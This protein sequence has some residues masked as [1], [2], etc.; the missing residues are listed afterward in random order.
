MI[1]NRIP[2]KTDSPDE[3]K[4]AHAD[5]VGDEDLNPE[6][7]KP[8]SKE[9][10]KFQ[11][12][13]QVFLVAAVSLGML[14]CSFPPIGLWWLAW[15]AYVPLVWLTQLRQMP[16]VHPYRQ[17]YLAGLVY[18]LSTFYFIP[19][20]HPLLWFGWIAVSVYMAVYTPMFVGIS[21]VLIQRYHV[22]TIVTVPIV[23]TGIEWIRCN[24][25]TGMAMVCLSHTQY[26]Q[27]ILI[28][29]ADLSGAYTLTFV[30]LTVTVG[31]AL[32][33]LQLFRSQMPEALEVDRNWKSTWSS[34][35]AAAIV[36]IATLAYGNLRLN[37]TVEYKNDAKLIVG[38]IQTSE[39]VIFGPISDAEQVRQIENRHMLTWQARTNWDDLDLLVWPE[40]GFNP[41]TDL[42]SDANEEVTVEA[43]ANTRLQAWSDA[44]GFPGMFSSPVPLLT[45]AGTLD[46]ANEKTYGSAL[47]IG[48]NGQVRERYFKIHLVMCG[49]YVPLANWFPIINKLSPI[50]SVAAGTEFV[51][52]EINGVWVSPN[53]CFETT[54]PHFVRRQINSLAA[55]GKEPDVMINLTNDG[56][57]YGTSCLD[58]HL[59]CNVFR[60]VEMRKPHLVCANTGFSANIDTCGR[61]VDVGER[62]KSDLLRAEVRPTVRSSV[63]RSLGDIL[64]MIFA[65]IGVI[66]GL[67]GWWKK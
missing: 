30:M 36:L 19:I 4:I 1:L 6:S 43:V 52:T 20:P 37:Q 31:I 38:L 10:T 5:V 56:W 63:Y 50:P 42:I 45:G 12:G 11:S 48:N 66:A 17:L 8:A 7:A 51:S 47:L 39:D 67:I 33:V 53:I 2:T 58:L 28:Q 22:P 46:P 57:F 26:E 13:F 23:G 9:S 18:W 21:R 54:I 27:P 34:M 61:L 49:E 24:F 25:A 3:P 59:A 60:A 35:G 62:R 14:W 40:S 65:A 29:V 55:Q 32:V 15:V 16:A 44:I 64:P 41:Y